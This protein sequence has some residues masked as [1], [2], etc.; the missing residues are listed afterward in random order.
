MNRPLVYNYLDY[1]LFLG[2]MFQ[3]RKQRNPHFSYR[4]FS[5]R[6]GFASPNFLKLVITGQRNLSNAS[7][8]KISKGFG[9]RK[10]EREFFENLVF[11]NQATAHEEKNYYYQ[12]IISRQGA[13][14]LH[15]LEKATYDYFAKWYNPAIRELI[16]MTPK[17]WSARELA[18]RLS[19]KVSVRKVEAALSLLQKIG[20]I[21]KDEQGFWRSEQRDLTTGPEIQ[22]LIVA[23]FHR[24]MLALASESIERYRADKRDI[25]AVTLS[26]HK[27]SIAEYK[28]RLA[29]FRRELLEIAASEEN[30]NH[31]I[32]INLQ[33]FPLTYQ[34]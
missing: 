24:E 4:Y 25:S 13:N 16:A 3:Y 1:R 31:V 5:K 29:A 9:L 22:S 28:A 34:E 30:P 26:I 6:A 33:L 2:D 12:K 23:N 14:N 11:M 7:T 17:N 32:Q 20:L 15:T 8:G 27:D 19:P 21:A 10:K 18:E